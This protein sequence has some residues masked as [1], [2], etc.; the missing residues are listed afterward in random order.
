[1]LG[2]PQ[3]FGPIEIWPL[4][5]ERDA[6]TG[7]HGGIDKLEISEVLDPDPNLLFV[8]NTGA[9]HVFLPMGFLIGGLKQS[10]MVAEDFIIPAGVSTEMSVM[11]VEMGR[12]SDDEEPRTAGRAPV[13]VVAAGLG[14][15]DAGERQEAV[16]RAVHAQEHRSGL[17]PTHSLE[18]VMTQDLQTQALQ[19]CVDEAVTAKFTSEPSQIGMVATAGGE[20]IVM[21]MFG[22]PDLARAYGADL[23]RG[24]AFDVD[25]YDSFPS[26]AERV[27]DFLNDARAVKF[28]CAPQSSGATR[29]HGAHGRVQLHGIWF[30]ER[31]YVHVM[32]TNSRHPVIQGI[33]MGDPGSH[34]L[35]R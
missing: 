10:R 22:N 13:S 34:V 32:A 9:G 1:M 5:V 19:R 20:P 11:C 8:T 27:L 30:G 29:I 4:H 12:F 16:W 7:F 28:A 23:I 33:G 31:T 3:E 17:Q 35:R 18:H 21:E 25:G 2:K 14:R 24:I 15:S 6:L 26:T